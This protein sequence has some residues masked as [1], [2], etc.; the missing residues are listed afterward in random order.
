MKLPHAEEAFVDLAKLRDYSLSATHPE[1]KHKARVFFAALGLE[2]RDAE[3]LRDQ[4]LAAV[5]NEHCRTGL[6][7]EF[8][9]RYTVDLTLRHGHREARIRSAWIIRTHEKFPRLVSCYVI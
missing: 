7:T 9:Q 1:G 8:G 2:A 6:L 4:L 3:W 5:L